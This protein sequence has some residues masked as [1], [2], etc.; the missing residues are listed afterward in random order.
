MDIVPVSGLAGVA[1]DRVFVF[2]SQGRILLVNQAFADAF[3]KG[4]VSLACGQTLGEVLNCR[5]AGVCGGATACAGCGWSQSADACKN[6]GA[7]ASAPRECR[8]LTHAHAAFDFSVSVLP[9]NDCGCGPVWLCGL[10]DISAQKRLRVLERAF[11]HDVTNLAAGV[12]GL[13]DLVSDAE[14][15]PDKEVMGLIRENADKVVCEIQ[16]LRTLRVAENG[17]LEL[18]LRAVSPSGILCEAVAQLKDEADARHLV[19]T[20]ND[21]A[22]DVQLVSD[23]EVLLLVVG[24]LLRNAIEASARGDRVTLSCDVENG[25]V[26]FRVRNPVVLS[27]DVQNHV[28]ERSFTTRGAGKGVGSYRAKLLGENYLKGRLSFVSR[29]QDGTVFSLALPLGMPSPE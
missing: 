2:G 11:F 17:D 19:V 13:M 5:H 12:R 18:C 28:F 24:D 10:R 26:V 14:G 20:V 22:G 8:S 6:G 1:S 25:G 23:H 29:E 27:A 9:L 3:C 7:G 21:D 16:R 15:V 4:D